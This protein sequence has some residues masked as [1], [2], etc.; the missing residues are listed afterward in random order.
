MLGE[1]RSNGR[2]QPLCGFQIYSKCDRK[3][4]KGFRE[5]LT[6]SELPL[7]RSLGWPLCGEWATEELSL[8]QQDQ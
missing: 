7:K 4:L 2:K 1:V 3:T 6:L 5:M 8:R